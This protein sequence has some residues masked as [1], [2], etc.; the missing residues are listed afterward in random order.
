MTRPS[1]PVP[2][3]DA[4]QAC[5][6]DVLVV[7]QAEQAK[8]CPVKSHHRWR[9]ACCDI[10]VIPNARLKSGAGERVLSGSQQSEVRGRSR[11]QPC[12][13]VAPVMRLRHIS[14][15]GICIEVEPTAS[16]PLF[17]LCLV[18]SGEMRLRLALAKGH[19]ESAGHSQ[20]NGGTFSAV[21]G[22]SFSVRRMVIIAEWLRVEF[23]AMD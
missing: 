14:Y 2:R 13:Q 7:K 20:V 8:A 12:H 18:K 23:G 5:F 6:E 3:S 9:E 19:L 15:V 21:H 11:V 10:C 22:K 1:E 16:C 17:L 4:G